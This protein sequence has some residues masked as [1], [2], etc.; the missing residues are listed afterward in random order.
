MSKWQM[1]V[2]DLVDTTAVS[3]SAGFLL[4][5]ISYFWN[6]PKRNNDRPDYRI[7]Q[8]LRGA[9][10]LRDLPARAEGHRGASCDGGSLL[11]HHEFRRFLIIL[12]SYLQEIESF[13]QI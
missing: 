1:Q 11:A 13:I 6:P 5:T 7:L 2:V 8:K 4:A 9:E 12:A 3:E 10:V